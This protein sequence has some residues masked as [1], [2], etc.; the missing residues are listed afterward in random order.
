M[1]NFVPFKSFNY[2][3]LTL[4]NFIFDNNYNDLQDVDDIVVELFNDTATSDYL[5][6]KREVTVEDNRYTIELKLTN[7]QKKANSIKAHMH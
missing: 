7:F 3:Q 4:S 6:S 5:Y 2:Y 1:Y